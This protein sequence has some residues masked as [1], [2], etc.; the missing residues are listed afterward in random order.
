MTAERQTSEQTPN[1]QRST[2]NSES[3]REQALNEIS[4]STELGTGSNKEMLKRSQADRVK[5]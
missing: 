3:F 4:D 1:A 5:D 2:F